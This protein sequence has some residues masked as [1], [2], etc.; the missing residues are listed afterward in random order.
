MIIDFITDILLET[1]I[2]IKIK[3]II[4]NW[5]QKPKLLNI[6]PMGKRRDK[7]QTKAYQKYCQKHI[8]SLIQ[9]TYFTDWYNTYHI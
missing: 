7:R 1:A 3:L 4:K 2:I 9:Y 6:I 8:K 5:N